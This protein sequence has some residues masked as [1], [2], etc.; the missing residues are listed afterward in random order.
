MDRE[1]CSTPSGPKNLL[2]ATDVAKQLSISRSLAYQLMLRGEIPT[3]R[4]G[5][6]VRVRECD[7][8]EYIQRS[9]SGWIHK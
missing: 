2:R 4:F 1:M 5:G 9:W 8:A 7:L 6:S 3:V